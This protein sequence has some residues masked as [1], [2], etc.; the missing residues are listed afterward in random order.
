MHRVVV[1]GSKSAIYDYPVVMS[2]HL[3]SVFGAERRLLCD[4]GAEKQRH[5]VPAGVDVRQK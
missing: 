3:L 1:E 2:V 4:V 5:G